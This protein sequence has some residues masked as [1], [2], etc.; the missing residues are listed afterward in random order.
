MKVRTA[1]YPGSF[2]PVTI[3]HLDVLQRAA[4]IFD[5]VIIAVSVN[6]NKKSF[7]TAEEKLML[8]KE[9]CAD[10]KNVETDSFNGLTAE[11]AA[12]KGAGVIIRGLRAVSDLEYEMQMASAN[13]ALHPEIQTVFIAAKP[14]YNFISSSTVREIAQMGGDISKFVSKPAAEFLKKK[15]TK[16]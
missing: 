8:I 9:S 6:I 15:F 7:L 13:R 3:G 1:V 5:K 14:E 10:M 12:E 16:G 4:L 11:Y 2:D